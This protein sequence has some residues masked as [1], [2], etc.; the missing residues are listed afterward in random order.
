MPQP[1]LSEPISSVTT[2]PNLSAMKPKA[3]AAEDAEAKHERQHLGAAGDAIAE[4]AAIG[5]D[6][7]LRHRHRDA[8]TDAG[9]A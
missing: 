1:A 5:D 7:D 2:P 9:N 8:A 6:M 4:V 3:N